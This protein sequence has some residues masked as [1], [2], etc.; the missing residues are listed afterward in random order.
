MQKVMIRLKI[1][2]I[3]HR[4]AEIILPDENNTRVGNGKGVA[5]AIVGGRF[6][7]S[8]R[9][10]SLLLGL[11]IAAPERCCADPSEATAG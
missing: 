4:I 8:Q 11:A 10:S 6:V 5:V 3:Q 1:L 9:S 7:V 2:C